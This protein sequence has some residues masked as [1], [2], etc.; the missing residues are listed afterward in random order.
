MSNSENTTVSGR[1]KTNALLD[2]ARFN[3]KFTLLTI[4]L[5]LVAAALE[6]VGLSFILPIVEIVQ[7]ED[8]VAEADGLMAAFVTVYQSL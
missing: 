1:E 8:P 3:P 4:G 6:E 2:V 5:G 7:A